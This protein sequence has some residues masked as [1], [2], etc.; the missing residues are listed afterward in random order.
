LPRGTIALYDVNRK[1]EKARSPPKQI[2]IMS[3]VVRFSLSDGFWINN[4]TLT[5]HMTAQRPVSILGEGIDVGYRD[6]LDVIGVE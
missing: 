2:S 4:S 5:N 3:V 6:K 1:H